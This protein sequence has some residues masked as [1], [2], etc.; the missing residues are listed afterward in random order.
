VGH[1][2]C[3]L[4]PGIAVDVRRVT[5]LA[6]CLLDGGEVAAASS[7]V[8]DLLS[9]ELLPDWYED[10]VIVERE[11]LRH[12]SLHSAE[13]LCHRMIGAGKYSEA[14]EAAFIGIRQEPL[15][16]SFRRLLVQT[17]IAEGNYAEALRQFDE[18]RALLRDELNLDPSP[19]IMALVN[20]LSGA[21]EA[22]TR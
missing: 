16:E 12:L 5:A 2:F 8:R 13:A 20:S 3:S 10:W 6:Q 17:L 4:E 7:T 1:D 22:A 21:Q 11:R 15:R 18:Y 14:I 19:H 9:G